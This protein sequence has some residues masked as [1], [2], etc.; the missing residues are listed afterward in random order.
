[1]IYPGAGFLR[2]DLPWVGGSLAIYPG[3]GVPPLRF[4]LGRGFPDAHIGRFSANRGV[5]AYPQTLLRLREQRLEPPRYD[6]PWVGGSARRFPLRFPLRFTLGRG[7][8]GRGQGFPPLSVPN[9]GRFQRENYSSTPAATQGVIRQCMRDFASSPA[10]EEIRDRTV[11]NDRTISNSLRDSPGH[12]RE[13]TVSPNYRCNTQDSSTGNRIFV[14][15]RAVRT[16]SSSS[17]KRSSV[18]PVICFLLYK[19]ASA[20][21]AE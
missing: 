8:P 9:G 6:L 18:Q 1:M 10:G 13:S 19:S 3:S 21:P 20:S 7:F 16:N 5:D 11:C 17:S 4:T 14:P 12:V 2:Y 15:D